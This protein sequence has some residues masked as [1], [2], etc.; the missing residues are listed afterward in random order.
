MK[1]NLVLLLFVLFI[2]KDIAA[3]ENEITPT[4][5]LTIEGIGNGYS[6][7]AIASG[8]I[9]ITGEHEGKGHLSSYDFT[10][11]LLWKTHYGDEWSANY[12]GSRASP[13]I[14]DSTIYTSSCIGDIAC[15]DMKTGEQRWA[16][17]MIRD[18][19]SVYAVFG[20]SMPVLIEKERIY[21]QPGGTDTNVACLNR[22]TGQII[23]TSG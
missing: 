7:P 23:W 20:Y 3:G 14:I 13:A 1:R 4:P 10:G 19:H 6:T 12:P 21:C 22:L 8:R 5:L 2:L 17:N 9:F 16:L 18:L 11:E 15:F